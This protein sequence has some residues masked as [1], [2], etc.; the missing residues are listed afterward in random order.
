[1]LPLKLTIRYARYALAL[2]TTAGFGMNLG[3]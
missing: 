2:L 1:M 3:N